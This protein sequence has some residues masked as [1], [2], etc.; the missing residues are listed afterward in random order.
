MQCWV[1]LCYV[2]ADRLGIE[3]ATCKSQVQ[4]S[5]AEPPRNTASNVHTTVHDLKRFVCRIFGGKVVGATLNEGFL[6]YSSMF[7]CGFVLVCRPQEGLIVVFDECQSRRRDTST[8]CSV[9]I[10]F[11]TQ[12][13]CS[14]GRLTEAKPRPH[15]QQCRRNVRLCCQTRQQC[16]TSIPKNF[17]L[18]TKSKQIGHAQF[19]ST[20]SKESFDL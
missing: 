11:R 2:K 9:W 17:V 20:L 6:V 15:Q 12:S 8:Q 3:P 7:C 18:S 5:T 4:R 16:R 14:N 10:V 19:V 13:H 1:D